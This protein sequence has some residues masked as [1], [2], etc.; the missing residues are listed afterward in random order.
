[1]TSEPPE[2]IAIDHDDYHAEHVGHTRDG[3][4]FFLTTPFEPAHGDDPGGE[5]VALFLFDADGNL[6]AAEIDDFG[7]RATVD[8]DAVRSR[9]DRRLAELGDVTFDRIEVKPFAVE[10]FGRRF[11]LIPREPEE[12]GDS[13][14]VE[15][16]PG[17]YMAF[18]EP[19][20]SGVYDT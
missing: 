20:D 12:E 18:F 9:Y 15:M 13:W 14:V 16:M 3:R 1:M 2:L 6:L 17:N 19:W 8:N 11:G 5:Y 10:N 7:P 4:Q